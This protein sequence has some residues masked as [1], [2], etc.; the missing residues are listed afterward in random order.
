[1][2]EEQALNTLKAWL[3]GASETLSIILSQGVYPENCQHRWLSLSELDDSYIEGVCFT[4]ALFG[5]SEG[6]LHIYLEKRQAHVLIDLLVGGSGDSSPDL[7]DLHHS[8]LYEAMQQLVTSLTDL[9]TQLRGKPV[10]GRLSQGVSNLPFD[11]GHERYLWWD[12]PLSLDEGPPFGFTVICDQGVLEQLAPASASDSSTKPAAPRSKIMSQ[13]EPVEDG[14]AVERAQS[15]EKPR[16]QELRKGP[17]SR[18]PGHLDLILDVPLKVQVVLGRTTLMVQELIHLGEGSILEL[19]KLAGEP[20]E[21]FVHD[22]LVAFGEVIV[23]DERFG[24]KVL[25]LASPRRQPSSI[26]A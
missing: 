6:Q 24:V 11:R 12:A 17:E 3:S 7:T 19:D 14:S 20:V 8:V 18:S 5:G 25:E 15:V 13:F 26:P 23:V 2:I 10:K 1:M 9:L 4:L 22:R 21:L 16:F